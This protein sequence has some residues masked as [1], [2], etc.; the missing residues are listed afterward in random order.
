MIKIE[1]VISSLALI[2]S[3]ISAWYAY[4]KNKDYIDIIISRP[5]FLTDSVYVHHEA[6]GPLRTG[7][8]DTVYTSI[9]I[10]NASNHDIGF[11]DFELYTDEKN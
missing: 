3:V 11:F 5:M 2:V 4:V 9:N 8:K 6:E 7:R 1:I 10:L